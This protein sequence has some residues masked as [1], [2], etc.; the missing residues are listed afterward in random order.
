VKKMVVGFAVGTT[1]VVSWLGSASPAPAELAEC[2]ARGGLPN[3]M[4]KLEAGGEVRVAYLGGSITDAEGWRVLSRQWLAAKYPKARVTE[5]RATI[6]GTGAEL[7]ACRL[8]RDVLVHRPDLLFVEF[9]VNGAGVTERRRI[10]S[11]EGIVRHTRRADPATDI[12]FV[13]TVSA[14]LLKDLQADRLPA[15]MASMERVADHYGVP[16]IH[17]GLDVARREKAGRL[18]F[19]GPAPRDGDRIVFSGDGVHPYP[20]TG[21][22]LYLEAIVRSMP[23]IRS[24]G[25]PGAH[26]LPGPLERDNW[27]KARMV[28]LDD[29]QRTGGWRTV[30][31]PG[32]PG[33]V[34]QAKTYLPAVWKAD[35]PGDSLT[36]RFRGTAFGLAGL[37]GPDSGQFIV[38][39]DDLPPVKGTHFDHYATPGR[40]RIQPWFHPVDLPDGDHRVRIELSA[41]PPDKAAILKAHGR[42]MDDPSYRDNTLHLGAVLLVGDLLPP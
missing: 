4:A 29:V 17:M 25:E 42:T 32:E 12:C 9:A 26:E 22:P 11:M 13:Y 24:A 7:G 23:A 21:H 34:Q 40:Y 38:T 15:V 10:E 6:P 27:E 2:R 16:S 19:R 20:D 8:G 18:V 1:V 33:G 5:I 36:F 39:V 41:E 3:V 30:P 37:R 14:S 35:R 31:P 28:P